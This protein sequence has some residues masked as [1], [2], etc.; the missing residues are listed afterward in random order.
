M[1][2][3]PAP[4]PPVPLGV[5]PAPP[6]VAPVVLWPVVGEPVPPGVVV[7]SNKNV[8]VSGRLLTLNA[9]SLGA[10]PAGFPQISASIAAT[11]YLLPASQGVLAGATTA[12][13]AASPAGGATGSTSSTS[14]TSTATPAA[15]AVPPTTR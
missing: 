1:A 6:P 4:V 11:A 10:A 14:P 12:G 2:V 8:A 5:E 15:V 13:P 7:A 9:I 3:V